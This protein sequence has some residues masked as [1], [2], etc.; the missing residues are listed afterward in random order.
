MH[1]AEG[2]MEDGGG[3]GRAAR[4]LLRGFQGLDAGGE[5]EVVDRGRYGR[6]CSGLG[7]GLGVRSGVG[8]GVG[9]GWR[10][11]GWGQSLGLAEFGLGLGI[12]LGLGLGLGSHR[13]SAR[14]CRMAPPP[15]GPCHTWVRVG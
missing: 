4:R 3:G 12:G 13:R 2:A 5:D 7:L 15:L 8:S 6:T 14:R 1:H 9:S 11:V 10:G